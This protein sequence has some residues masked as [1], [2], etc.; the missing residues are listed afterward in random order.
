MSNSKNDQTKY[1]YFYDNEFVDDVRKQLQQIKQKPEYGKKCIYQTVKQL[2][3]EIKRMQKFG[4]SIYQILDL[5]HTKGIYIK[6]TTFNN[7]LHR[8]KNEQQKKN[9]KK[10]KEVQSESNENAINKATGN[11]SRSS[12]K[13]IKDNPDL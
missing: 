9:T 8:I 10:P 7:Y 3:D 5:L 12:F 6:Y 4:Y 11:K 2:Y 1:N 13:I